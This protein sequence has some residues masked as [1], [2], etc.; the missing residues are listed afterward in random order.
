[1]KH[2]ID[3]WFKPL[4]FAVLFVWLVAL[5]VTQCK[6]ELEITRGDRCIKNHIELIRKCENDFYRCAFFGRPDC[7][8]NHRTCVEPY[9][10]C[11][12]NF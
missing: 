5:V 10:K 9:N 8:A 12:G 4:L 11:L 1:M 2:F 7:S 6:E 3:E